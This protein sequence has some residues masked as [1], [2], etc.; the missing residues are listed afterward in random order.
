MPATVPA[1]HFS[2][3]LSRH[4]YA[5]ALTAPLLEFC[6]RH[7]LMVDCLSDKHR[8]TYICRTA[9]NVC[10]YHSGLA[11]GEHHGYPQVYQVLFR[12][13]LPPPTTPV[14]ATVLRPMLLP[15][16]RLWRS[17][18]SSATHAVRDD[19]SRHMGPILQL[20]AACQLV[21]NSSLC[22]VLDSNKKLSKFNESGRI[23]KPKTKPSQ[24]LTTVA[25]TGE[26]SP[27]C[28]VSSGTCASSTAPASAFASR[29][30]LQRA[31]PQPPLLALAA[32]APPPFPGRL[33]VSS[34]LSSTSAPG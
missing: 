2:S 18:R 10:S 15:V 32:G 6:A 20:V 27:Q 8:D 23:P 33:R 3:A 19:W 22:A 24:M 34:L 7:L 9:A 16:P 31:P 26:T 12:P 17:D 11:K 4:G 13:K 21:S 1:S 28:S 30:S 29:S 5:R 25:Q 14:S